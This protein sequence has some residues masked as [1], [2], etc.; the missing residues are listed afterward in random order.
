MMSVQTND[1]WRKAASCALLAEQAADAVTRDALIRMRNSWIMIA[2]DAEFLGTLD[3]Q[4]VLT[5][6][7]EEAA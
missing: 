2:N 6:Q 5:V 1:A 3:G 4:A 7:P